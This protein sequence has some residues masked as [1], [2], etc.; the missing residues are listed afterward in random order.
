MKRNYLIVFT[1]YSFLIV[2]VN[3]YRWV[4]EF[5]QTYLNITIDKNEYY[6][7]KMKRA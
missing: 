3:N 4:V 1:I 7:I 2:Y 5:E 6:P